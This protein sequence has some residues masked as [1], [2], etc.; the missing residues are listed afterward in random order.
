MKLKLPWVVRAVWEPVRE[1]DLLD[2]NDKPDHGKIVPFLFL[3]AAFTAHFFLPLT[4]WELSALGS[5]SFGYGAWRTF[6]TSKTVS[7]TFNT[8][9]NTST[10][11]IHTI[12]ERRD[13]E[14]GIEPTP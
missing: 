9:T 5:L 12:T 10:S 1:L 2:K 3:I 13:P 11:V 4:W 14:K 6:L 8:S 7:G